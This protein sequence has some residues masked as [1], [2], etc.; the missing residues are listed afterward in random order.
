ML[1][2]VKTFAP[3]FLGD[4]IAPN[5]HATL[6]FIYSNLSTL[7]MIYHHAMAFC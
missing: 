6:V 3:V 7:I 2:K 5:Y 1:F 4:I